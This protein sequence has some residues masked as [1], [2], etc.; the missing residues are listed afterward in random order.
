MSNLCPALSITYNVTLLS[1]RFY[2]YITFA[3]LLLMWRETFTVLLCKGEDPER[4]LHKVPMSRTLQIIT[5]SWVTGART[6]IH[7]HGNEWAFKSSLISNLLPSWSSVLADLTSRYDQSPQHQKVDLWID[8]VE[9]VEN[10]PKCGSS[11]SP[12]LPLC[13]FF[14]CCPA[15]FV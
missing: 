6:C 12:K 14:A 5:V 10:V 8:P 2:L 7:I 4:I 9:N 13:P 11:F 1:W 3:G 15:C